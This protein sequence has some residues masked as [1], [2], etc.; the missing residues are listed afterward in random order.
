MSWPIAGPPRASARPPARW[1]RWPWPGGPPT[2]PTSGPP[3]RP[4]SSSSPRPATSPPSPS[5][6][7]ASPRA[8]PPWRGSTASGPSAPPRSSP[9]SVSPAS[10]TSARRSRRGACGRC[11]GSARAPRSGSRRSL[12]AARRRGPT[13][14]RSA[15]RWA[16]PCPSPRSSWPGSSPP[17]PGPGGGGREPAPGPRGR[18]RHRPGR[19]LGRPSEVQDALAALPSVQGVISRGE[20]SMSVATHSGV[21]VELAVGPPASFGNLLQ[22]A[23]GS[24]AHNVRLRELAVRGGRS[25]SQHG[26]AGPGGEVAVYPDEEGVYAALGLHPIPPELREDRG[27]IEAAQAGPLPALVTRADLRGTSTPTPA[28]ATAPRRSRRWSRPLG[29]AATPTWPSAT[30]RRASRWPAG[31]IPTACGASGR[32]SRRRMPA[33]TTSGC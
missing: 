14:R 7:T 2:C 25:V 13:T 3:S 5:S 27:E 19:G 30:T 24:A 6:A 11:R 18:P 4:R 17:C 32:R 20:A 33:T 28:G 15:C 21:R 10:T 16:A 8:W 31:W 9:N 12:P 1:P 29:C 26:I 23:T 22:H